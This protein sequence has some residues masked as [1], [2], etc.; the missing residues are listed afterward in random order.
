MNE[1]FFGAG[2][3]TFGRLPAA[4][5]TPGSTNAESGSSHPA[6][7]IA[8]SVVRVVVAVT[9]PAGSAIETT[10]SCAGSIDRAVLGGGESAGSGTA[11]RAEAAMMAANATMIL[12][13][14]IGP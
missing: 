7:R 9:G 12:V 14:T 11:T 13:R 8:V 1:P 6:E 2:W 5:L 3:R 10:L 4:S